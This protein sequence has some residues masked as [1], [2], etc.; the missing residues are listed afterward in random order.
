MNSILLEK[1]INK[2][3]VK[4]IKDYAKNQKITLKNNEA[5]IIYSFIKNNYKKLYEEK[6]SE[7]II[8]ELK[9]SLSFNTYEKIKTLYKEAK[10]KIR[11]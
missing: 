1:Y 11:N 10:E 4:N 9:C 7:D 8:K 6:Y 2:L 3:T 5:D